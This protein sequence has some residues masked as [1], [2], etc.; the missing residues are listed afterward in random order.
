MTDVLHLQTRAYPLHFD[1]PAGYGPDTPASTIKVPGRGT[2]TITPGALCSLAY[3]HATTAEVDL[4]EIITAGIT[5]PGTVI[6]GCRARILPSGVVLVTYALHHDIDLTSM[7]AVEIAVFDAQV[8]DAL[9]EADRPILLNVLAEVVK[10]FQITRPATIGD[11][12]PAGELLPVDRRTVRYTCHVVATEATWLPEHETSESGGYGGCL[13]LLPF[14]YAWRGDPATPLPEILPML[15]PTDIAVAQ[16]SILAG[17][18][19]EGRK[20]LA[21]LASGEATQVQSND[22]RRFLDG[23]W[24]DFYDLDSYRIESAQG[25]RAIFLAA[26]EDM[27]MDAARDQAQALLGHVNASLQAASSARSE[28]L[29]TRLNRVAAALT[30]VIAAGFVSDLAQFLAPSQPL[31]MRAVIVAAVLVLGIGTLAYT[32]NPARLRDDLL[33][34]RPAR[35]SKGSGRGAAL[36]AGNPAVRAV[37]HVRPRAAPGDHTAADVPPW[38]ESHR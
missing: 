25:P 22:F 1:F 35:T 4:T 9:R 21:R 19:L 37:G 23:V 10:T 24:A 5:L 33:R 7:S 18:T 17:A 3:S 6:A 34:T 8:N 13:T 32:I 36:T 29:D 14:T 30:V 31:D 12:S 38:R 15:E 28:V 27:E 16:R 20:I 11:T 26:S 2:L